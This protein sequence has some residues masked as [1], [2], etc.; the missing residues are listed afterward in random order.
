[1]GTNHSKIK[2]VGAATL[3]A[4]LAV[5]AQATGASAT[6]SSIVAEG[7]DDAKQ[8][9]DD[10]G[11][12]NAEADRRAETQ[13][14]PSALADPG[15]YFELPAFGDDTPP[16]RVEATRTDG[17]VN[18]RSTAGYADSIESE[19]G[20]TVTK[21][22][23]SGGE[24]PGPYF[25]L[26]EGEPDSSSRGVVPAEESDT[27]QSFA[28]AACM[29]AEYQVRGGSLIPPYGGWL[30]YWDAPG[31]GYEV[32]GMRGIECLG[33]DRNYTVTYSGTEEASAYNSTVGRKVVTKTGM[34]YEGCRKEDQ[35]DRYWCD[36]SANRS[37]P[38][39]LTPDVND[40]YWW[41][42]FRDWGSYQATTT[43]SC[44]GNIVG[45]W[46]GYTNLFTVGASCIEAGPYNPG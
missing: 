4:P 11:A 12:Q 30:V 40:Q 14:G 35:Y 17:T 16:G 13:R 24:D 21:A 27:K 7:P 22:G 3:V 39:R 2:R 36:F 6:D 41:R 26:P 23:P 44:A 28:A 33:D 43:A 19:H 38:S 5:A 46:V 20:V 34:V 8:L 1:M 37:K 25:S 10:R 45:L 15:P 32:R 29:G 18:A 42:V 31:A 9:N